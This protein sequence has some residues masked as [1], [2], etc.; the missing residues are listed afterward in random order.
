MN[1][2]TC[3]PNLGGTTN[4]FARGRFRIRHL[5]LCL[6]LASLLSGCSTLQK[7]S[8]ATAEDVYLPRSHGK[9]SRPYRIRGKTYRPM[10]SSKGYRE[11]GLASWYGSES[12]NRTATGQRFNPRG[13]SAA[14]KTLPLPT[15]VRVTNLENGQ[16]TTLVVND[17]GPFI[18]GRLIDLSYGAAKVLRMH[19]RGTARVLVEALN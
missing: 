1:I 16:S 6:G 18:P 4:L 17:R 12:G 3:N 13:L 15:K 19:R 7:E 10:A 11:V 2:S 14:H 8:V 5:A 9:T